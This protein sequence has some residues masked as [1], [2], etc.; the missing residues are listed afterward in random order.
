MKTE[1]TQKNVVILGRPNV[2]KSTLFNRLVGRRIAIESE[3]SGTTRDRICQEV[4]WQGVTF[5]LIDVAGLELSDKSK[6]YKEMESSVEL[7]IETADLVVLIVD[8]T[9]PSND[10]DREVAARIR[11][12]KLPTILAVN[13]VD[14]S[15]REDEVNLFERLGR[16]KS[17]VP[18]SAVS[19]RN[20]GDLLDAIT[21]ELQNLP[22]AESEEV[23]DQSGI[24]LTIL[25]RPNVG[26][27]TLLNAIVGQKRAVVSEIPGTTR[28]SID[29]V[30]NHKGKKIMI[31]DTAGIRRP[32]KISKD[33]L[34]SF[35]VIR[36]YRALDRC[37]VVILLVSAEEGVT[38]VDE[39]LIGEA[40]ERGKGII[41]AINK[42]DLIEDL[43]RFQDEI[44]AKLQKQLKFI[45]WLPVVFV[46]ALDNQNINHLL[47][48]VV[49]TFEGKNDWIEEEDLKEILKLA[50]ERNGQLHNITHLTQASTNPPKFEVSYQSKEAPHYTQMRYLENKIRDVFPFNGVPIE[51]KL[52]RIGL[53]KKS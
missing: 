51:L 41:L 42:I 53:K 12:K 14:N 10:L 40:M 9:E 18:V 32:G 38:N 48:L 39:S 29:V 45:P 24:Q 20:S 50:T 26:K 5:N 23:S 19:G 11:R 16:F 2:G 25:G 8:V 43:D 22:Q 49:K 47:N 27:S 17:I 21:H 44:Q 3:V 7:A 36:S 13:K 34:E 46:S 52:V 1:N 28:D 37:D 31:A 33:T 35:S 15:K 30:F 6:L 4:S